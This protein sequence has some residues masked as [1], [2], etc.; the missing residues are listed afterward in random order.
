MPKPKPSPKPVEELTYEEAFAELEEI[1]LALE[2]GRNSLDE[3]MKLFERGQALS[4]RCAA[5]LESA[6][7]QAR[8]LAGDSLTELEEEDE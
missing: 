5:L 1:A 3:A 2:D 6:R 7:L 8:R 4:A